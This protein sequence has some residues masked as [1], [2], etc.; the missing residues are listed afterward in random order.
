MS[1]VAAKYIDKDIIQVASDSYCTTSDSNIKRLDSQKLF[2]RFYSVNGANRAFIWGF[3]GDFTE[4][5]AFKD[6]LDQKGMIAHSECK[7][8]F[9]AGLF[10]LMSDFRAWKKR[11]N[12][13]Y[14]KSNSILIVCELGLFYYH[15]DGEL[16]E[17][18][19]Q[20]AI[21]AGATAAH[22]AMLCGADPMSAVEI[23]IKMTHGCG[24]E[25]KSE[26]LKL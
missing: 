5:W 21:G 18:K 25:V 12:I 2:K 26:T 15:P 4:K 10:K 22:A 8:H 6:F 24:G 11:H 17:Y 3:A 1:V 9:R 20:L 13:S 14:S 16:T 19:D 23:A 7:L